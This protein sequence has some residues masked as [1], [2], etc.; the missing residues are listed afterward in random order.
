MKKKS[1]LLLLLLLPLLTSCPPSHDGPLFDVEEFPHYT[2]MLSF[3]LADGLDLT[4]SYGLYNK[5]LGYR[6]NATFDKFMFLVANAKDPYQSSVKYERIYEV[7]TPNSQHYWREP[8]NGNGYTYASEVKIHID[9]KYFNSDNDVFTVV[10][11]QVEG[12]TPEKNFY[13]SEF[14]FCSRGSIEYQPFYY[15][16]AEDQTVYVL[17]RIT[18]F[19]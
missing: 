7:P 2:K 11:A 12:Y 16:I 14:L 3:D 8:S 10:L 15:Y 9:S 13:D 5:S 18:S 19:F 1:N 6:G 17:Y 4:L